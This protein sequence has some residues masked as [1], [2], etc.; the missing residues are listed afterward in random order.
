M[1]Q[2]KSESMERFMLTHSTNFGTDSCRYARFGVGRF[3]FAGEPVLHQPQVSREFTGKSDSATTFRLK[4]EHVSRAS[5]R[6]AACSGG[7]CTSGARSF[8]GLLS[9]PSVEGDSSQTCT[10]IASHQVSSSET[11]ALHKEFSGQRAASRCGVAEGGRIYFP[12]PLPLPLR[13]GPY[14]IAQKRLRLSRMKLQRMQ[15]GSGVLA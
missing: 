5:V 1:E 11:G 12:P 6:G 2:R 7:T 14:C 4:I 13:P 9:Q 3:P 15:E 10:A 8:R